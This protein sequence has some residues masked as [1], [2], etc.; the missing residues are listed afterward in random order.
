M[1][2][3]VIVRYWERPLLIII[4]EPIQAG[5]MDVQSAFDMYGIFTGMVKR[6]HIYLHEMATGKYICQ[7]PIE[8]S[9]V[10]IMKDDNFP[11][12]LSGM[13]K[14]KRKKIHEY[15][16]NVFGDVFLHPSEITTLPGKICLQKFPHFVHLVTNKKKYYDIAFS[17]NNDI[18]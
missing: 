18:S 2:T 10:Q 1:A 11:N 13:L 9:Y 7:V 5:M 3:Y 15:I 8:H 17:D 14:T 4:N 12:E 6:K 16:T